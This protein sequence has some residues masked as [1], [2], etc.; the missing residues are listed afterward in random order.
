MSD[1]V[2]EHVE[3]AEGKR[4]TGEETVQV[5]S[6]TVT[7]N[8]SHTPVPQ[9]KDA[10]P[11]PHRMATIEIKQIHIPQTVRAIS[12]HLDWLTDSIRTIGLLHPITVKSVSPSSYEL[13]S[14]HNRL[15]AVKQLGW[16]TVPANVLHYLENDTLKHQLSTADEN[17]CRDD[18]TDLEFAEALGHAKA[19]YEQLYPDTKHN[20]KKKR[21]RPRRCDTSTTS[22][23]PK[24]GSEPSSRPAFLDHESRILGRS[25]SS[26]GNYCFIYKN[27][28]KKTRDLI[29]NHKVADIFHELHILA[30]EETDQLA[31][32]KILQKYPDY[33]V[34]DAKRQLAQQ[35]PN[36]S[37]PISATTGERLDEQAEARHAPAGQEDALKDALQEAGK[38]TISKDTGFVGVEYRDVQKCENGHETDGIDYREYYAVIPAY[39]TRPELCLPPV[40]SAQGAAYIYNRY[41][42]HPHESP[43]NKVQ[44]T[45]KQKERLFDEFI[46]SVVAYMERAS[47]VQGA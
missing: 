9:S 11:F 33:S 29:R 44:L 8:G 25:R 46:D 10:M 22:S 37:P 38:S 31:L 12:E 15:E 5:V 16:K 27:L 19:L 23:D 45:E 41:M 21:G 6:A 43:V 32:A 20:G 30:K 40:K 42:T 28:T 34:L 24:N 4:L 18:L 7:A 3:S 35:R 13:L 2:A 26:L 39:G 1:A 47:T 36:A 17:L 14:G